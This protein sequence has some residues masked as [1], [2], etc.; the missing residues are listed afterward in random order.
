MVAKR[1]ETGG[2]TS[3]A[4]EGYET[5]TAAYALSYV[6]AVGLMLFIFFPLRGA[7]FNN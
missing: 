7:V 6:R 2:A 3:P 1:A 4:S 5:G